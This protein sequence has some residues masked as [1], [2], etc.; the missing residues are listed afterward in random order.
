MAIPVEKVKE[1]ISLNNKGK[2]PE[3]LEIFAH[4]KEQKLNIETGSEDDLAKYI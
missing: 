4:Q 2:L 1:L 3:E